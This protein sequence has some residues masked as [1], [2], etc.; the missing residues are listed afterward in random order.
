[1]A[2]DPV[3]A[4]LLRASFAAYDH[5][6]RVMLENITNVNTAGYKRRVVHMVVQAV[7]GSD[8]QPFQVPV[9][10]DTTAIFTTG[11][12]QIT[13]RNLDVAIDG[14][15]FFAVTLLDGS[16]GYT[17]NGGLQI[18]R[19]G[20][21]RTSSG[22]VL[23]PEITVPSDLLELSIDPEGRVSGRCAGCPD[24]ATGFGQ[25]TVHRF[26]NSAGLRLENG[27]YR[28]SEASGAPY[29]GAPGTTGLGLL[30]QGVLEGSNVQ[31]VKEL[32]DLQILEKQHDT[33]VRTMQQFGMV[34]P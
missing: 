3:I 19:D 16:T 13:E 26:V 27:I 17:R 28:C 1:L 29:S 23:L 2:L 25:L 30:K 5:Q 34:A 14:D 15:G 6:R 31:L 8:G 21:L 24:T 10:Q 11:V 12:L 32:V 20:K 4:Q 9:V 7:T 18:D 33:L 22:Y